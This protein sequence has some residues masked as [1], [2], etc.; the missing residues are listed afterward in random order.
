MKKAI[1]L[2]TAMNSSRGRSLSFSTFFNSKPHKL[3]MFRTPMIECCLCSAVL[4][5]GGE[6]KS[7]EISSIECNLAWSPFCNDHRLSGSGRNERQTAARNKAQMETHDAHAFERS[8]KFLRTVLVPATATSPIALLLGYHKAIVHVALRTPLSFLRV[9]V[10][11]IPPI[12]VASPTAR[13]EA[14][15][16]IHTRLKKPGS[17]R[18]RCSH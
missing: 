18:I 4:E 1:L 13:H 8:D 10:A 5:V 15:D 7:V 11:G 17:R 14:F 3:F 9:A 16:D 6:G 12:C 2:Q